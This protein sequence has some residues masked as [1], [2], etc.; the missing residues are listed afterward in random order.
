MNILI[1]S[2]ILLRNESKSLMRLWKNSKRVVGKDILANVH[3]YSLS[4]KRR[5]PY[6]YC[7][8]NKEIKNCC[9]VACEICDNWF[10]L[11]CI[12]ISKKELSYMDYYLCPFCLYYSPEETISV[13][14]TI[15]KSNAHCI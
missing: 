12:N 9:M 14:R 10:H 8:C 5:K 4:S 15:V 2:A 3:D 11:N 7:I 13:I 6:P 1:L